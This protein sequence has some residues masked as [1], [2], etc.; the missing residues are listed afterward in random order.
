M[1]LY[2]CGQTLS[3]QACCEDQLWTTTALAHNKLRA[4][5][6]TSVTEGS[7]VC[8]C[9]SGMSVSLLINTQPL[10]RW[11]THTNTK[12]NESSLTDLNRHNPNHRLT[13]S[14]HRP[15]SCSGSGSC[16]APFCRRGSPDRRRRSDPGERPWAR[17]SWQHGQ[18]GGSGC[19]R[20]VW[21]EQGRWCRLAGRTGELVTSQD[22]WV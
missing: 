15:S 5:Q 11:L 2:M 12:V 3:R 21:G 14:L 17:S 7:C 22:A 19:G 13:S 8:V 9:V 4:G 16:S 20:C 10:L 18:G 1:W 6:A